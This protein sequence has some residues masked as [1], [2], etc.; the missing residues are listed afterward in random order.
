M[1]RWLALVLVVG[2][3]CRVAKYALLPPINSPGSSR[4]PDRTRPLV[5][6]YEPPPYSTRESAPGR[7]ADDPVEIPIPGGVI[8]VGTTAATALLFLLGG[9]APLIGVFGEFEEND[10]APR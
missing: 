10:L 4:D 8:A 1:R 5:E 2:A 9:A 3:G 7:P 6:S